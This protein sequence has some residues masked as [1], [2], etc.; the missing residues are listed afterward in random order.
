MK[1]RILCTLIFSLIVLTACNSNSDTIKATPDEITPTAI[2]ETQAKETVRETVAVTEKSTEP[3]EVETVIATTKIEQKN[4][5]EII[6]RAE[7]TKATAQAQKITQKSASEPTTKPTQKLT[8][9]AKQESVKQEPNSSNNEQDIQNI[10]SYIIS[11]NQSKGMVYDSTLNTS[12]SGWLFAYQGCLNTTA[13]R[14]YEEQL[15]RTVSGL[16]ADI[17]SILALDGYATNYTQI[18]FNCYA[19]KQS[20]GEYNIYFCYG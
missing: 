10:V 15:S 4:E 6:E 20:D 2:V 12:N 8:E 14:T 13:N 19:E 18:S 7:E 3:T 9:K 11:H 1:K 16:D 5:A 17:D